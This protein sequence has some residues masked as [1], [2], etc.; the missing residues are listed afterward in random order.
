[1]PKY[2]EKHREKQLLIA[3]DDRLRDLAD[4][5]ELCV[6]SEQASRSLLEAS[7]REALKRYEGIPRTVTRDVPIENAPNV[8]I[9]VGATACDTINAQVVDLIWGASPL[10]TCRP[11][12]KGDMPKEYVDAVASLQSFTNH[13]AGSPDV[14]LRV[15][16]E[17]AIL[18]NIQLGTGFLYVPW[19]E[20]V[21]KTK[22]SKILSVGPIVRSVALEDIIAPTSKRQMRDEM[23]FLG[24]NLYYTRSELKQ[25]AQ[26]NKWDIEAFKP[27][28]SHNWVRQRREATAKQ[29]E[30]TVFKGEMYCVKLI[31]CYFDI[32]GDG[33]DEDLMVIFN[34]ESGSVGY[35]AYNPM[36]RRPIEQM[37]YQRRA[38]L[39]YGLGVMDMVR[40]YEEKLTDVHNYATLN[41][42]LA[43][44]RVWV[45]DG[46]VPDNLRIYPGMTLGGLSSKDSLTSLS[47]ADVYSSIWQDQQMMMGLANQRV[48]IS[49]A[50]SQPEVPNR[51]PGITTMS[52]LQQVNRR[53]T[54][55]F[56]SMRECVGGALKQCLYRFQEQLLAGNR[57]AEAA[58]FEVMGTKGFGVIE[59]LKSDKFD[60]AVS[61]ELTAASASINREA[62]KQNA[63][64]LTNLL[65][66]YQQRTLELA[67]VAGNPQVPEGIRKIA[68][69]AAT[70]ASELIERT[71]RTFDSIRDPETFVLDVEKEMS[72]LQEGAGITQEQVVQLVQGLV[73]QQNP[74]QLPERTMI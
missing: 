33:I 15:A 12:A 73:D 4:W 16:A 1:M 57:Y 50:M 63:I 53:F 26:R 55:A 3:K 25:V 66:Q 5:L 67:Q 62:D 38:H 49:S 56:Q 6:A 8:H 40:P 37:L 59:L 69:K 9:T 65:G 11:T 24:L 29:P 14:D 28:E 31:F 58:I 42:L 41:I 22:T 44:S 34:Q 70:V 30:G 20:R 54:P 18:D 51:S 39:F 2:C 32:D 43:N 52:M 19:V 13:L 36:D 23:S 10:V 72:E 47:M 46:S 48:G 21:K 45:G 17:N 61:V 27:I 64:M 68:M 74:N 60:E 7:W 71:V 35:Y